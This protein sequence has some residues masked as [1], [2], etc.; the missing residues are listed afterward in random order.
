MGWLLFQ[1]YT[2]LVGGSTKLPIIS[3]KKFQ[4]ERQPVPISAKITIFP[5]YLV[6]C[7]V[8][9]T[10]RGKTRASK[11]CADCFGPTS[12]WLIKW[13]E[14]WLSQSHRT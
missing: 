13:R 9:S 14:F 11:P 7:N 2:D 5:C 4:T 10:K 3:K 1:K 6:Y 12:D 8:V